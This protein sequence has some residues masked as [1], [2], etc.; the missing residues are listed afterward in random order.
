MH[1]KETDTFAVIMPLSTCLEKYHILTT[2]HNTFPGLPQVIESLKS[3]KQ[4]KIKTR[5]ARM[6]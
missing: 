2:L 5:A 6:P 4:I 1:H 3:D